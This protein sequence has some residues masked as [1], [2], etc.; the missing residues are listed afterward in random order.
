MRRQFLLLSL[1]LAA[2]EAHSQATNASCIAV[3]ARYGCVHVTIDRAWRDRL[4]R[5]GL[6][7]VGACEAFGYANFKGSVQPMYSGLGPAYVS[8]FAQSDGPDMAREDPFGSL[9]EW[10]ENAVAQPTADDADATDA[11]LPP[12]VFVSG[13]TGSTLFGDVH[14]QKDRSGYCGPHFFCECTFRAVLFV[15]KTGFLPGV[16]DCTFANLALDYDLVSG[17]YKD[18][19]VNVLQ[20]HSLP[21]VTQHTACHL[22]H[23]AQGLR[24]GRKCLSWMPARIGCCTLRLAMAVPCAKEEPPP[25]RPRS[26]LSLRT[27][28]RCGRALGALTSPFPS[29]RRASVRCA[30]LHVE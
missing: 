15:D 1:L 19:G 22:D 2:V 25:P 30:L 12:I 26:D 8:I 28:L 16:I 6:C 9:H 3:T 29:R 21:P 27:R 23:A 10:Q 11:I 13:L 18:F 14:K 20:S 24:R 4:V 5:D 7:V 17:V